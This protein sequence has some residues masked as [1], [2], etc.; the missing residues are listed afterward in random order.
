MENARAGRGVTQEAKKRTGAVDDGMGAE[1]IGDARRLGDEKL[2]VLGA[3]APPPGETD[4]E[5]AA[6][7]GE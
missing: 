3:M 5:Y 4:V 2:E 1:V 7:A 6:M